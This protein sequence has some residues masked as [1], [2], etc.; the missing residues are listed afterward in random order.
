MYIGEG[1]CTLP[2]SNPVRIDPMRTVYYTKIRSDRMTGEWV[3]LAYGKD[4]ERIPSAD[5]YTTDYHD[6]KETAIAMTGGIYS[7]L[8]R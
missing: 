3:V 8:K 7:P 1:N 5:Y 6:A 2:L 4:S